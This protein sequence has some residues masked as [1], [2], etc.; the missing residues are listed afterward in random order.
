MNLKEEWAQ[1]R[2]TTKD[3][4]YDSALGGLSLFNG[5]VQRLSDESRKLGEAKRV[6]NIS[7]NATPS[8]SELEIEIKQWYY[9]WQQ[10]S[11]AWHSIN[12]LRALLWNLVTPKQV[13]STLQRTLMSLDGKFLYVLIFNCM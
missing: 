2:P 7:R 12:D 9:M 6:L 10:I 4:D 8:L 5:H 1:N 11:D 13:S 3:T